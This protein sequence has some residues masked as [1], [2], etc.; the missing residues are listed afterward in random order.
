MNL[1]KK[2]DMEQNSS[3]SLVLFGAILFSIL[4]L[5]ECKQ[6]S[7][8]SFPVY[9]TRIC[10]KNEAEWNK[11]S[12]ALN[13][14]E[15]N[16]YMCLPNQQLTELLEFCYRERL[17]WIQDGLCLYL[18]KNVSKLN[19]YNCKNFTYGCHNSSFLSDRIFEHPACTSIG[20][21][22]FLAEAS[23]KRPTTAFPKQTTKQILTGN[24]P[25]NDKDNELLIAILLGMLFNS[26]IFLILFFRFRR[27]GRSLR[28]RK[29]DV[30]HPTV[31]ELQPIIKKPD[32][33]NETT[34]KEMYQDEIFELWQQENIMFIPTKASKAVEKITETTNLVIVTGNS[35]SGKSAIIQHIA[36]KYRERGWNVKPVSEVNEIIK[37]KPSEST[38]FVFDDPIGKESFDEISYN[39]WMKNERKLES[40]LKKVNLLISCRKCVLKDPRVKGLFN[41]DSNIVDIDDDKL[42]LSDD[43]KQK[44]FKQYIPNIRLTE[45]EYAEIMK[46]KT[47]FPLLCHL[48]SSNEK[49]QEDW[50][51]FFQEPVEVLKE[52]LQSLRNANKKEKYCALVLLIF[53]NNNLCVDDLLENDISAKKFKHSL[54][55][56]GIDTNTPP[57]TIGDHLKSLEG[58]FVKKIGDTFHFYHDFIMEVTTFVFGTDYPKE[59]IN[60]ADI[61]FLRR[62]V[63]LENS[64]DKKDPLTLHISEKY[65]R[66]LGSRFLS[67]I[68]HDRLLDVVLNPC[69]RNN[70]IVE[71]LKKEMINHSAKLIE[72]KE[73]RIEKQQTSTNLF[74]SKIEFVCLEN[75]IS[76]LFALIVF[77]HTD[78][79]LYCLKQMNAELLDGS[80][81]S[82]VCCNGSMDL[83]N[84]FPKHRMSEFLIEK[85]KYLHPIHI[86]SVF[87]NYKILRELIRLEVDVNLQTYDDGSSPL[88]LA[89]GNDITEHVE[90]KINNLSEN[91]RGKTIEVLLE[92][93]GDINLRR[94]DGASP[95]Y[96]ACQRGHVETAKRLLE[97][98]ADIKLGLKFNAG[99]YGAGVNFP[100]K[101]E[102]SPVFATCRNGHDSTL[103]LLLEYGADINLTSKNGESLLYAACEFGHQSVVQ[104]ILN[105]GGEVNQCRDDGESPLYVATKNGH[106]STVQLLL[107]SGAEINHETKCGLSPIDAARSNGHV[108]TENILLGNGVS[109]CRQFNLF[110]KD[111]SIQTTQKQ[112]NNSA[113]DKQENPMIDSKKQNG[114]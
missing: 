98:G 18:V 10:P 25:S 34:Q 85:W 73:I 50:L 95:L 16:G 33:E 6:L 62:R 107:K 69:L 77:H 105:K 30:K 17:I 106:D 47:Y 1:A 103:Q 11:R 112:K 70:R 9:S 88:V 72:K 86:A 83:F 104:L 68:L 114:I 102:E 63:K 26:F 87:H 41:S 46:I 31:F 51:R 52:E 29:N 24:T 20:N 90:Y 65:I 7:G 64:I 21:G 91:M 8:Y 100:P 14:S 58:F 110:T 71:F 96:V 45:T 67:D 42:K 66:C 3:A 43:E 79:S 93:N 99:P 44:I 48:Y 109:L 55:L 49:Y 61:G 28:K 27:N 32:N 75:E 76:P 38:M 78:L 101:N 89:A 5:K 84:E 56:C 39:S 23:C 60:Y 97:E 37:D 80:L 57:Y 40:R 4:L 15:L 113:H 54:K 94:K 2:N 92:N 82:A 108:S 13:C 35:G 36:L 19:G 53:F 22:C 81:F 111:R 12:S 59:L 74:L